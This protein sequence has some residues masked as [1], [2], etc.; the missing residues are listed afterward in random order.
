MSEADI[1][2]RIIRLI[3]SQ[4]G[5]ILEHLYAL[6]L[7][8]IHQDKPVTEPLVD[9][10]AAYLEMSEDEEREIAAFEWIEGTLESEDL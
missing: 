1:K 4:E 5:E 8:E 7:G 3:D 9:L 6:I 10:E 2:L